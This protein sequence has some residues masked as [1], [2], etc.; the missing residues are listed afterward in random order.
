[1]IDESAD[2]GCRRI[3]PDG[4]EMKRVIW[5]PDHPGECPGPWHPT[6]IGERFDDELDD[7]EPGDSEAGGEG[8]E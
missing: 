1:M 8:A 5:C 2:C 7:Y 3:Q 4:G 6:R